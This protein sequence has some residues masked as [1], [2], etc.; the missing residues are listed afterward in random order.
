VRTA[1]P[2][3]IRLKSALH[4]VSGSLWA[5]GAWQPS[6]DRGELTI[7]AK[8][9][10]TCQRETDRTTP[11]RDVRPVFLAFYGRCGEPPAVCYSRPPAARYP[12][13]FHDCH[14]EAEVTPAGF[15]QLW[16][17]LWKTG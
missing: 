3:V 4:C 8:P 13:H 15:P 9:F 17:K 11:S 6:V 14:R 2:A 10:L 7:L 5:E 16:K 12:A 1:T